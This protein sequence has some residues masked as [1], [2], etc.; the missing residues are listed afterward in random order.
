V[1][2]DTDFAGDPDDAWQ[3]ADVT[4]VPPTLSIHAQLRIADLPRLRR[5]GVLGDL[6]AAQSEVY[7]ADTGKTNL[8]RTYAALPDDLV[9]FHWDPV[10]AAVAVGWPLGPFDAGALSEAWLASV[11]AA[12]HSARRRS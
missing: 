8:G 1:H 11:K 10:T 6:L 9:N 7:A 5:A 12:S 4:L 2:L 3:S